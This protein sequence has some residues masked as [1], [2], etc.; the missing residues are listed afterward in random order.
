MNLRA[1]ILL[2]AW[3]LLSGAPQARSADADRHVTVWIIPPE[4]SGP[5]DIARG[6]DIPTRM[7]ALRLSLAGTRVRLLNVEDPLATKAGSHRSGNSGEAGWYPDYAGPNFEVV[8]NQRK[9]FS[10]L[11]R[12]AEQNNIYVVLRLITWREAFELL[13]AA[14]TTG[15]DALPDLMEVGTTWTGNLAANGRI[16]SRPDWQTNRGN[17]RDVLGMPACALPYTTDVRL[18]FY[19]KRLPSSAPDSAPLTLNNSSWPALLDSLGRGTSSADT[20]ALPTAIT[21]NLLYDYVS[22]VRAGGSQ[23]IIHNGLFGPRVSFSSESALAVPIYLTEHSSVPLGKGEVRQLI[24]FPETTHE[25]V[26]RAFVNGGY[27]TTLETASFVSRWAEDFYERQRNNGKSQRFWDYAAAAVP[28]GGFKGGGELV[29]LSGTS[30]PALAFKLANYLATDPEY[31]EMLAQAGFLPPGRPGYGVNALVASLAKDDQDVP[32]ARIFGETVREAIDQGDRYP[33][34]ARWP[35][36]FENRTVLEKL[37]RVWRG[38]AEG[39]VAGVRQAA[40]DVD[41]EINSQIYL[42]SRA[43]NALIQSWQLVAFLLSMAALLLV[44]GALHRRRLSQVARQ[45]DLR[46]E[47]RVNERTRIARD[48]HDTLLQNFQGSLLRFQA[49]INLLQERPG[50]ALKTLESAVDQAADAITEGRDAVQGLRSSA[51]VTNDLPLAISTLGEELAACETN[52]HHAVFQ[53]A[54]EG[55]TRVLH[56]ILRDEV[57]RIAAEALRNAFRHAHAQRIEVE[58]RYDERQFRLRVRDNGKGIREELSN[59]AEPPGHYGLRGMRERAKLLGGKLTVWSERDSGTEVELR[60]PATNTYATADG[61][62]RSRSAGKLFGKG[63]E[64]KP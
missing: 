63:M 44:A 52:P 30:D 64:R 53:V 31:T 45:F 56:P 48:L 21:L 15:P 16:R 46:L 4:E 22:L 23:S 50:E 26:T 11:A 17:W 47:E 40:K 9:T 36:V 14:R 55:T 35:A 60:L 42:P 20:I 3:A 49:G 13:R 57:Y 43:L 12:F 10:A 24:S 19:W 54:V 1:G 5:N 62:K 25:E 58:I 61:G 2:V 29:V 39:D 51:L 18:L 27:R 37:Q 7:E 33:D 32:N 59:D 41:W 28:T 6:E 38:M 8:V 34:F